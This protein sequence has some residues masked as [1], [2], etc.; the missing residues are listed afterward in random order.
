MKL[1]L[2][3]CTRNRHDHLERTLRSISVAE[4]RPEQTIISDDSDDDSRE[5]TEQVV[6]AF[7]WAKYTIG[8]RCGLPRNRNN[9]IGHAMN[10]KADY[11]Q[12]IDDDVEVPPAFFV[13]AREEA[14][15]NGDTRITTGWEW[16]R[17]G[18]DWVKL[19]PSN[20][21]FWGNR[22][23]GK[24][25]I[26]P[27]GRLRSIH[28]NCVVFPRSVFDRIQFDGRLRFGY[29]EYDIGRNAVAH[30]YEIVVTERLWL[31][32]HQQFG[33]KP[34]HAQSRG[35]L[36][37]TMK[38]HLVHRRRVMAFVLFTMLGPPKLIL[39]TFRVRGLRAAMEC[40]LAAGGSLKDL[41]GHL[42]VKRMDVPDR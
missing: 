34:Q 11:I 41:C 12:M 3:I 16:T 13:I 18:E 19:V 40:L 38:D 14:V 27:T 21:D 24:R 8:P 9:A 28:M 31:W 42:F 1:V 30:G 29:S 10:E 7:P 37:A 33:H 22:L 17:R 23:T 5:L 32:H 25:N 15:R 2:C 20:C 6:Q 35:Y 4:D 36:Y 26:N 39:H